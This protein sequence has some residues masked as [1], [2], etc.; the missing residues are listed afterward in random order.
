ML[1]PEL[2]KATG[3]ANSPQMVAALT[4]FGDL[5]NKDKVASLAFGN[6]EDAV[7]PKTCRRHLPRVMVLSVA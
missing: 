5:V 6:P 7:R 1:S 4:F 3:Y 2:D